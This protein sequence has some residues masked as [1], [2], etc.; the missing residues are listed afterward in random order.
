MDR[1][2]VQVEYLPVIH[3]TL[4][5][6]KNPNLFAERVRLT[7]ARAMNTSVTQH[8]YEDAYM[9]MEAVRLKIDSASA[10]LEFGEFKKISPFTVKEA[11]RCLSKFL[12]LDCSNR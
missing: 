11:K 6:T 10:L 9:A 8:T 1:F 5:E 7:M 12:A 3:P 4:E 2:C